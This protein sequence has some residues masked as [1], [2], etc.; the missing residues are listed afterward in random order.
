MGGRTKQKP[1][2]HC[3]KKEYKRGH[4][5]KRRGRDLNQIQDDIIKIEASGKP[6]TIVFDD[7]L[8][9]GGQFYCVETGRHFINKDSLDKHKKSRMYRR[10]LKELKEEQYSQQSADL[11]AGKTIEHLPPAHPKDDLMTN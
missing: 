1:K 9:G 8:P 11:A 10:R 4:D 7:D 6:L 5:T 2:A 3:K